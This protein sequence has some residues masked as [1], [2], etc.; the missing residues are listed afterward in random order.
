[1][2]KHPHKLIFQ[3]KKT[4]RCTLPGC[5]FFVHQGLAHILVGKISICWECNEEFMT[6][7]G[8]LT[9]DMPR[10]AECRIGRVMEHVEE[11]T[12]TIDKGE[13]MTPEKI[14]M[15]KSLGLMK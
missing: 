4:W 11:K 2:G 8:A 6:D 15:Y 5:S 9:E 1:M 14:A 3:Q 10:C 13:I 12:A 7:E